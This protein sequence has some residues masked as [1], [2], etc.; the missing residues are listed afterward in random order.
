[1]Q[2]VEELHGGGGGGMEA[3]WNK[4]AMDGRGEVVHPDLLMQ[5]GCRRTWCSKSCRFDNP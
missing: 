2:G 4:I 5:Q 1:M 3:V